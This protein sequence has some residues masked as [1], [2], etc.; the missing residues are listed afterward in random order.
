MHVVLFKPRAD[1]T[2]LDRAAFVSAVERAIKEIPTV[3]GVRVGRRVTFGAGYEKTAPDAADFLAILEFDDLAALQTYLKHPAHEELGL[4]FNESLV[5]GFVYDF[6][7][8]DMKD[9]ASQVAKSEVVNPKS[10]NPKSL[11]P[12]S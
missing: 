10:L 5:A 1:L 7:L 12:K 4:G 2:P 3:R 9:M 11:N 8:V 6:E